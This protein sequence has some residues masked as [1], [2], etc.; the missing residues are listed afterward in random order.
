MRLNLL[1]ACRYCDGGTFTGDS[2]TTVNG[3]TLHFRGQA[4]RRAVVRSL[5]KRMGARFSEGSDFVIGGSSAV[6]A[7]ILRPSVPPPL[8]RCF[9]ADSK[10]NATCCRAASPLQG[11]LAVFLHLDWWRTQLPAAATVAGL[12]DS[13]FFLDWTQLITPGSFTHTFDADLRSGFDLFNSSEG[14]ND[15][16]IADHQTRPSDCIFAATTLPYLLRGIYMSSGILQLYLGLF[17][18]YTFGAGTYGRRSLS[19]R[20]LSTPGSFSG[21][22]G[23][24]R[25]PTTNH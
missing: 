9:G 15:A 24:A 14:V 2:T 16:C 21:S 22:T 3:T 7:D 13:G 12:A 25:S 6:C 20:A 19:C 4:I 8:V 18:T 1:C 5:A 17:M 23:W 10:S 11:G